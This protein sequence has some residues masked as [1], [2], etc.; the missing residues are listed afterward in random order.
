MV[1]DEVRES[2]ITQD[3]ILQECLRKK[4]TRNKLLDE[5]DGLVDGWVGG[6]MGRCMD[7]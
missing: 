3:F 4:G 2:W 5:I 7:G 1:G 6:R